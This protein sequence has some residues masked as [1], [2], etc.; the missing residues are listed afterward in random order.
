MLSYMYESIIESP[1]FLWSILA[2]L[3][4]LYHSFGIEEVQM[5]IRSVELL[6]VSLALGTVFL[7]VFNFL[8]TF[9]KV[10][11]EGA[12][13]LIEVYNILPVTFNPFQPELHEPGTT[14][15]EYYALVIIIFIFVYLVSVWTFA[16]II[17]LTQ[18]CLDS[19]KNIFC[20][21]KRFNDLKKYN[22]VDILLNGIPSIFIFISIS[23]LAVTLILGFWTNLSF[24]PN[25]VFLLELLLAITATLI[26]VIMELFLATILYYNVLLV[27]PLAELFISKVKKARKNNMKHNVPINQS[28]VMRLIT[29][30]QNELFV[31]L[32]V[33][34][35]LMTTMDFYNKQVSLFEWIFFLILLLLVIILIR[36][37]KKNNQN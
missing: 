5:K 10:V 24:L 9:V 12:N 28:E 31:L 33:N 11:I 26:V 37:K 15:P 4:L 32:L 2:Y 17:R 7:F 36:Y 29:R 6:F 27:K 18:F 13:S 1:L 16:I 23:L 34:L 35:F 21:Y 19:E 8:W 20:K 30:Y 14:W 25:I 3:I 22:I